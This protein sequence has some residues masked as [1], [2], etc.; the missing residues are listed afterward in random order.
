M[1]LVV[2]SLPNE[3]YPIGRCA[4]CGAYIFKETKWFTCSLCGKPVCVNCNKKHIPL[5]MALTWGFAKMD[6]AT[7]KLIKEE[8]PIS[9]AW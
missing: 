1:L 5:C 7:G 9:L 3:G 6:P 8:K 4:H 2:A